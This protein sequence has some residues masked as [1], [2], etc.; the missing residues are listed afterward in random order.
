MTLEG[1]RPLERDRGRQIQ[2]PG[3]GGCGCGCGWGWGCGCGCGW[4]HQ[5]IFKSHPKRF[6]NQCLGLR[7]YFER[8]SDVPRTSDVVRRTFGRSCIA[9]GGSK[10]GGSGVGVSPLPSIHPYCK[11]RR[12]INRESPLREFPENLK[13]PGEQIRGQVVAHLPTGVV[14]RNCQADP[15]FLLYEME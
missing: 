6:L 2:D 11:S 5:K 7:T 1:L 13:I 14:L 12:T 3:S 8:L 9:E 10:A 4:P 15:Q